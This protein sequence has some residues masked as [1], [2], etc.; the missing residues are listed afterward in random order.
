VLLFVLWIVGAMIMY[1]I[2][3]TDNGDTFDGWY[4]LPFLVGIVAA[5]WLSLAVWFAGLVVLVVFACLW[6][7]ARHIG[8]GFMWFVNKTMSL[9]N[10]LM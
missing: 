4:M 6:W 8:D 3:D 5:S 2:V 9:V 7:V 1:M 10:T